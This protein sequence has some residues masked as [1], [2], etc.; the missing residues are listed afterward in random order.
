MIIYILLGSVIFSHIIYLVD[1]T[2]LVSV[3]TLSFLF[4][5]LLNSI[6]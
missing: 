5:K 4:F 2:S 3:L 6:L 1:L